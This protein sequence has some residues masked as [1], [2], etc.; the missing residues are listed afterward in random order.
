MREGKDK[1]HVVVEGAA[2]VHGQQGSHLRDREPLVFREV[3]EKIE[4]TPCITDTKIR[5]SEIFYTT[6]ELPQEC[7]EGTL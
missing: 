4:A 2:L 5:R 3:S 6:L 7:W 1:A